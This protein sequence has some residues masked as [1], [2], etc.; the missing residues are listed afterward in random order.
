MSLFHKYHVLRNSHKSELV[1]AYDDNAGNKRI[2]PKVF[3][4]SYIEPNGDNNGHLICDLSRDKIVG[5]MNYQSVPVPG[6][7][8]EP[9]NKTDPSNQDSS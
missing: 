6:D 8:I 3:Y 5:T 1:I 4:S 2:H 7:L 9:M